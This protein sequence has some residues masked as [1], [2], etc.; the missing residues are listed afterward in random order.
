MKKAKILLNLSLAGIIAILSIS[1]VS[2]NK[3]EERKPPTIMLLGGESYTN[4]GTVAEVGQALNFGIEAEGDGANLTN[5]TVKLLSGGET[6]TVMDSGMN[7]ASFAINKIFYQGVEDTAEW[8]FTVMDKNRLMAST[9]LMI[10]KDPNSTFGGI[11]HYPSVIVG[12][13]ENPQAG[14]FFSPSTGNVWMEDSASMYPE[15]IDVLAYFKMSEDN[16][17][18]KPSPTFSSPGEDGDGVFEFYPDLANWPVRNYTKW[19]I[20]ADNGVTDQAF[21]NAYNDSLLIVSYD[22]VWGKRKFKWANAGTIIPFMTAGGKKGLVRV[23]QA[24][25]TASGIIE[26]EMKIQY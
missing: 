10:Y 25:T 7:T 1:L 16:G 4:N 9:S 23:L 5:F 3:D 22:D 12:M 6:R 11:K 13:D 8:V 17:I 14:H 19:D 21:N 18:L 24:D 2:C 26:F 20:R 15:L